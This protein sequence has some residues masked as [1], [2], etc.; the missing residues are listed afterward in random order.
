MTT[1]SAGVVTSNHTSRTRK[2]VEAIIKNRNV[3]GAAA[4]DLH[5]CLKLME[6]TDALPF[7]WDVTMYR[8]HVA[9]GANAVAAD[10]VAEPRNRDDLG[11][12]SADSEA[13]Q[14]DQED[15]GDEARQLH[16][17]DIVNSSEDDV[18]LPPDAEGFTPKTLVVGSIYLVRLGARTWGLAK[19]VSSLLAVYKRSKYFVLV[20][21][22]DHQP[23][24]NKHCMKCPSCGSMEFQLT[25]MSW[26]LLTRGTPRTNATQPSTPKGGSIYGLPLSM[27]LSP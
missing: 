17:D 10:D 20:G 4:E 24:A 13:D 1:N 11:E 3:T 18:A 26:T 23:L 16:F 5:K 14:L 2:G 21:S 7:H 27:P 22:W 6:S 12:Q 8:V 25:P 19:Y 9:H 15:E